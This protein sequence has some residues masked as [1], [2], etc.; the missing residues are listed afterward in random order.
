MNRP[1]D[2]LVDPEKIVQLYNTDAEQAVLGAL[3]TYN[4]NIYKIH[5]VIDETHFYEPVHA[6]IY[7]SIKDKIFK[8]EIATPITLKG[9]YKDDPRIQGGWG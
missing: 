5:E 7:K 4:D 3:L 9:A 1:F 8:G 6:D 2:P